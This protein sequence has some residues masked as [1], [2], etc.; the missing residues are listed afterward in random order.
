M[1]QE[2]QKPIKW[3]YF[4]KVLDED[5]RIVEMLIEEGFGL[6]ITTFIDIK[7]DGKFIDIITEIDRLR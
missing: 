5:I 4:H 6:E 3:M 1:T 2:L 7:G